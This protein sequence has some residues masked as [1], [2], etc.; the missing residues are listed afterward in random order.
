MILPHPVANA[1]FGLKT[2]SNRL[3]I[4]AFI[5]QGPPELFNTH[6]VHPPIFPIHRD[7]NLMQMQPSRKRQGVELLP[8]SVLKI[9]GRP[10][11]ARKKKGIRILL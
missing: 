11:G 3:K 6:M 7:G 1:L 8:W 5:I 9:S 4:H 10:W 2:V